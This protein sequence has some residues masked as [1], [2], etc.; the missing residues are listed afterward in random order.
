MSRSAAERIFDASRVR[1]SRRIVRIKFDVFFRQVAGPEADGRLAMCQRQS[2]RRLAVASQ[3]GR[4]LL[5]IERDG[6]AVLVQQKPID[7][8]RHV[9]FPQRDTSVSRG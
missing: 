2:D 5:G 6:S 7:D 4:D 3:T 8:E 1:H 9:L